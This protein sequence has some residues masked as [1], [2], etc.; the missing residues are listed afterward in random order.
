MGPAQ[1][2]PS[3]TGPSSQFPTGPLSNVEAAG[4]AQRTVGTP[5][6][7]AGALKAELAQ[8]TLVRGGGSIESHGVGVNANHT[9]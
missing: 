5:G 1:G 7:I 4:A 6:S 8:G 9:A 2:T 3:Y